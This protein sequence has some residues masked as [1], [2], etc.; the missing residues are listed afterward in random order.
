MKNSITNLIKKNIKEIKVTK[1]KSLKES[2]IVKNRFKILTEG[3]KLNTISDVNN[4]FKNSINEMFL[5]SSQGL[6]ETTI[7]EG[8]FEFFGSLWDEGDGK[9]KGVFKKNLSG[10]MCEQLGCTEDKWSSSVIEDTINSVDDS[11]VTRL[12]TNCEYTSNLLA[13]NF[14]NKTK[15]GFEK[16]KK[17]ESSVTFMIKKTLYDYL[18]DELYH[19]KLKDEINSVLCPKLMKLNSNMEK[20]VNKIKSKVMDKKTPDLEGPDE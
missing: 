3:V 12:I 10:W 17:T 18:D 2:L 16:N 14:I 5:M 11:N 1:E 9:V 6:N 4:V 8:F 7:N 15:K 20:S 19:E 13:T